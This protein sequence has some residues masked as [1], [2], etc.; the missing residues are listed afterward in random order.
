MNN[1]GTE[2]S[3]YFMWIL[4][5]KTKQNWMQFHIVQRLASAS[6][7]VLEKKK[8]PQQNKQTEN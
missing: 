8:Q 4:V 7:P 2:L 5:Q 1:F 6:M 3:S